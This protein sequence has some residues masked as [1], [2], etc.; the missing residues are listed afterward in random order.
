[1]KRNIHLLIILFLLILPV[2]GC[3]EKKDDENEEY[4][5]Y[6]QEIRYYNNSDAVYG[7]T[8]VQNGSD[9]F[10]LYF[11]ET[12]VLAY[13]RMKDPILYEFNN[14]REGGPM[15]IFISTSK[16]LV[17]WSAPCK[18]VENAILNDFILHDDRAYI[19][20]FNYSS[21][22]NVFVTSSSDLNEWDEPTF[23]CQVESDT[24]VSMISFDNKCVIITASGLFY[25]EDDTNYW[26]SD[27]DVKVRAYFHDAYFDDRILILANEYENN[28]FLSIDDALKSN[29][30]ASDFFVLFPHIFVND[31]EIFFFDINIRKSTY[32]TRS[33]PYYFSRPILV[34]GRIMNGEI[35]RKRYELFEVGNNRSCDG[36]SYHLMFYIASGENGSVIFYEDYQTVS[37]CFEIPVIKMCYV[38]MSK[39][40]DESGDYYTETVWY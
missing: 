36:I 17:S 33:T 29:V 18:A 6:Q 28:Y 9:P 3:T 23:I 34:C 38:D 30:L 39:L 15:S 8:F 14:F 7:H 32:Y 2:S 27:D 40:W 11:N 16:D 19:S 10:V 21:K 12:Y 31:D 13:N 20:F 35:E 1:M 24:G 26:K 22:Q 37:C 25:L 5:M 4:V